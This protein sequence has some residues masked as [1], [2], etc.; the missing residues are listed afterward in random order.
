MSEVKTQELIKE[1]KPLEEV[2]EKPG[3]N[4]KW[5]VTGILIAVFN[6]VFAGLIL[7]A[8]YLSEPGLRRE[9][10]IVTIIAIA[11]GVFLFFWLKDNFPL[12]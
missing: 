11:W 9:G 1:K 3:L 12:Y 2:S 6:P 10:R 5:L 4:K 8:A 7:G